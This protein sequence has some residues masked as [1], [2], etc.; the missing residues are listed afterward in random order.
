MSEGIQRPPGTT[1]TTSSPSTMR[2]S[3]P[4]AS[5]APAEDMHLVEKLREGNET[6]FVSL[7]DRHSASMLHLAMIYIP[8]RA[9]A[10]E[11]V[12]EAW[13]GVLHGLKRFEGRSSLKTWIF[14]IL[15]NCAKTRAQREAR[16]IPFSSLPDFDADDS[17]ESTVDPDRFQEPGG[18]WVSFPRS[19]DEIPE[20]RLLS[21]ETRTYISRAIDALPPQ[22]R[23]VIILRDIEGWS[24]DEICSF[25]GVSEANVRVLLHRARAK[26]RRELE[27]YFSYSEMEKR[28]VI[29]P[30]SAQ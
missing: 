13:V 15:T 7:I 20:E 6:A 17:S 9:V 10:E 8:N 11:V 30:F 3:L 29:P 4:A 23:A 19:W 18:H 1:D 5:V 14:R 21:Q 24:S 25:L 12:Q 16:S 27:K 26:V 28:L 22:Q 2:A